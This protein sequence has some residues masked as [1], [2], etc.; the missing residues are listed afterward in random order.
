MT[1]NIHFGHGR[2]GRV[3]LHRVARVIQEAKPDLIALQEVDHLRRRSGRVAQ[4]E[5]IARL[6]EMEY[7]AGHNWFLDEGAYGNVFLAR[8]PV[9]RVE[10]IDLSVYRYEPRGCLVTDVL[11]GPRTL[12]VGTVHLGLGL[13]ERR[14][15][16][17]RLHHAIE[18][19][20]DLLVGDFN[21]FPRSWVSRTLR[22]SY[23][24]AFE[25]SGQGK[26]RTFQKLGIGFRLDYIYC[27]PGW[28]PIDCRIVRG[29]DAAV[30]SDHYPVVARVLAAPRRTTADATASVNELSVTRK[31]NGA[32]TDTHPHRP[33][34]TSRHDVPDDSSGL[35]SRLTG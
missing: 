32:P 4:G 22:Q 5:T 9:R 31:S 14:R 28:H 17:Y 35:W 34:P 23:R 33:H 10:N 6:L 8:W 27:G 16:C 11:I 12:R 25:Q 7:A 29:G 19:P 26:G 15:Q 30:A 1:Y 13:E 2:D 18:R 21:A 20:F 24:D 3:D